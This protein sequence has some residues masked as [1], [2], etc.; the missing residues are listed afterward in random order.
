MILKTLQ[1]YDKSLYEGEKIIHLHE[2]ESQNTFQILLN[3]AR[4][5]L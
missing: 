3:R 1:I 4:N 2:N 5:T